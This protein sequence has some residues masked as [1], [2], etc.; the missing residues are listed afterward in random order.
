[1]RFETLPLIYLPALAL[2]VRSLSPSVPLLL[3]R[4][5]SLIP[6]AHL[7]ILLYICVWLSQKN[8]TSTIDFFAEEWNPLHLDDLSKTDLAPASKRRASAISLAALRL[9]D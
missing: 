4:K 2:G 5:S 6:R 9:R 1:M 8:V 3:E 7:I